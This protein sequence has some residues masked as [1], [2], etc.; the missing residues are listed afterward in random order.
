[1]R[2]ASLDL[3]SLLAEKQQLTER[4]EALRGRGLRLDMSRGKPSPEQ[5]A[6]S[7]GLLTAIGGDFTDEAGLD[8]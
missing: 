6:L 1:M 8:S 4:Y 7:D 3:P 2:Y 5:S